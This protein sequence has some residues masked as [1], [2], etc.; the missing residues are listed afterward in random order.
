MPQASGDKHLN[1]YPGRKVIV[2]KPKF[3]ILTVQ[4]KIVRGLKLSIVDWD[5]VTRMKNYQ[6][7]H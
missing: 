7:N 2:S 4:E 5:H 3:S 1:P 6:E